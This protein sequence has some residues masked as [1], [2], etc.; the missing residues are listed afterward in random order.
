[1][2]EALVDDIAQFLD[3]FASP[4]FQPAPARERYLG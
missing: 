4:D 1:V 2:V 3:V